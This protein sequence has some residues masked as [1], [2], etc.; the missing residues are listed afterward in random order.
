M[1]KF[2]FSLAVLALVL[3]IGVAAG[4]FGARQLRPAV[5]SREP[6]A[7][8]L[9]PTPTRA[10]TTPAP[11]AIPPQPTPT[12][13]TS[14]QLI[15]SF[16]TS[17]QGVSQQWTAFRQE[18]Q[19]WRTSETTCSAAA[20]TQDLRNWVTRFDGLRDRTISLNRTS[21]TR[22]VVESLADVANQQEQSLQRLRD[23]WRPGDQGAFAVYE[24]DRQDSQQ[25]RRGVIDQAARLKTVKVSEQQ[26]AV[27]QFRSAWDNVASDW[28][29]FHTEWD[30]W[31][32]REASR[33]VAQ[34]AADLQVFTQRFQGIFARIQALPRSSVVVPTAEALIRAGDR[35]TGAL[36]RLRDRYKPDDPTLFETFERDRRVAMTERRTTADA[37]TQLAQRI[38]LDRQDELDAFSDTF[39][40]LTR[41]WDAFSND[42]DSW[43]NQNGNC[44]HDD[45][46]TR[47]DGF[48]QKFRGI[49]ASAQ[50]LRRDSPARPLADLLA[51]A[52]L[53]EL[54]AL[55]SLRDTWAPYDGAA[56]QTHERE[57]IA[58]DDMRSRVAVGLQTLAERYSVTLSTTPA[59]ATG[60]QPASGR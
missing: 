11:V 1:A 34:T 39:A 48:V 29:N 51:D 5:P 21:L 4:A 58:I 15:G 10:S 14:R 59:S 41:D 46:S 37:L 20:M 7:A 40:T 26:Q 30:A 32:G 50:A 43:R 9:V 47:L 56:W 12:P 24:R 27:V 16:A 6:E 19:Q 2:W 35:E 38:A 31:R 25:S 57:Q 22:P 8:S 54:T 33:A 42:Y 52:T 49:T 13:D 18:F 3:V 28:D 17:N 53:R 45:V 23:S 55:Q 44:K 60:S 36:V